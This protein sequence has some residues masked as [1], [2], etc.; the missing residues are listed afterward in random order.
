MTVIL[1][2]VSVCGTETPGI[3]SNGTDQDIVQRFEVHSL[4]VPPFLCLST[5]GIPNGYELH[6]MALTGSDLPRCSCDRVVS[7]NS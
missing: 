5:D 6:S 2:V 3:S 1:L 7:C 4:A